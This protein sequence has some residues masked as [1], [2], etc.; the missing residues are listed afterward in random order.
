MPTSRQS[1]GSHANVSAVYW[2][3]CRP[4]YRLTPANITPKT[5]AS[6]QPPQQDRLIPDNLIQLMGRWKSNAYLTYIKNLPYGTG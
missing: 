3:A 2:M 1:T 6:E 5:S 4:S